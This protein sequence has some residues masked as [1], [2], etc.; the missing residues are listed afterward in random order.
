[1]A[2][3]TQNLIWQAIAVLHS[4]GK[5]DTIVSEVIDRV[6]TTQKSITDDPDGALFKI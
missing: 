4:F 6:P 3:I 2:A 5:P 1:M